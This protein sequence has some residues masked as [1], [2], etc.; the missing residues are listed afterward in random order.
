MD[1]QTEKEPG[2][3]KKTPPGWL[4]WSL[5]G[6]GLYVLDQASKLWIVH[7]FPLNYLNEKVHKYAYLP[8]FPGFHHVNA[9]GTL[10]F[11]TNG[12]IPAA[13]MAQ[14]QDLNPNTVDALNRLRE[15]EPISFLDGAVNIT[16]VHNTGVAFGLGNGT[17]WSSYLF[18]AIPVLAIV[19]L[20]VLYRKTF[21]IRY[22]S[23]WPMC[24]CWPGWRAT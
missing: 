12:H 22:G 1:T 23:S 6:V 9:D 5:L 16:R 11:A 14:F 8:D 7:R 20:V 24:C 18:L 13:D 2:P 15:L 10:D 17:A 21:S 4:W 19:A 3:H